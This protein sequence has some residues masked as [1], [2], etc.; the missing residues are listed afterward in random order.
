MYYFY[1][2]GYTTMNYKEL[3]KYVRKVP[4]TFCRDDFNT[5]E[6]CI[7][8]KI[9]YI[10]NPQYVFTED[11]IPIIHEYNT[12]IGMEVLSIHQKENMDIY[13]IYIKSK[14]GIPV[15][16]VFP[17]M[18]G[19]QLQL[20]DTFDIDKDIDIIDEVANGISNIW[21]NDLNEVLT[22]ILRTY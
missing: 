13:E 4:M 7:I 1:R 17:D 20:L 14:N 18:D 15:I 19:I 3:Y 5:K 21:C 6:D 8:A 16:R 9:D 2:G 11:I 22:H 10:N 12:C